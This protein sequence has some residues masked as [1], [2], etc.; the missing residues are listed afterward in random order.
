MVRLGSFGL[1][2]G[3]QLGQGMV[4]RGTV[5][6]GLVRMFGYGGFWCGCLGMVIFGVAVELRWV[7]SR[8]VMARYGSCGRL[9][10]VTAW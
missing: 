6:Q 4:V 1:G 2:W 10:F 8:P 9:G 5:R 7:K 3:W